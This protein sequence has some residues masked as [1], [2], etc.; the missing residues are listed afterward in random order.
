MVQ[1]P[2]HGCVW[3][4]SGFGSVAVTSEQ[5]RS[6]SISSCEHNRAAA[7]A[8]ARAAALHFSAW[9]GCSHPAL[10][11]GS[12]DRVHGLIWTQSLPTLTLLEKA[13][14]WGVSL[15]SSKLYWHWQQISSYI[16]NSCCSL[17]VLIIL[18]KAYLQKYT[19]FSLEKNPTFCSLWLKNGAELEKIRKK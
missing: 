19:Y 12:P 13:H 14:E 8:Q 15:P 1:C 18:P 16:S 9:F 3:A 11:Q 10:G 6:S 17:A 7:G 4:A 5:R 2:R